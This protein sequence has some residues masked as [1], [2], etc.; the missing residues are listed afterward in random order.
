MGRPSSA[1]CGIPGV[2]GAAVVEKAVFLK[3]A[4][5]VGDMLA[6]LGGVG[7]LVSVVVLE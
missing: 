2:L 7:A 1:S 3:N 5:E 4:L 6:G